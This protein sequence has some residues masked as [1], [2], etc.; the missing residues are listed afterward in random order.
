MTEFFTVQVTEVIGYKVELGRAMAAQKIITTKVHRLDDKCVLSATTFDLKTEI[1][2]QALTQ[3]TACSA[4]A[5]MD[6]LR[7]LAGK[8][9]GS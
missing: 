6:G 5:L 7:I 8:F 3:E 9:V 4:G 1:A 2:E